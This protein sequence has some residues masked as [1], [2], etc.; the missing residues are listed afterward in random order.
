MIETLIALLTL[1]ITVSMSVVKV[2][3]AID[4][5]A[6]KTDLA[7]SGLQSE[8]GHQLSDIRKNIALQE[9]R[10]QQVE[11]RTENKPFFG[12]RSN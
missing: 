7:I 10:L 3:G 6:D 2:L 4:Q 5:R 9:F 11:R 12:G 1:G 8:M